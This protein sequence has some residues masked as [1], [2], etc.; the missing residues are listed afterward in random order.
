MEL[1]GISTV[2]G[3]QSVEKTTAN[4]LK[5]LA[6]VGRGDVLVVAGQVC[7]HVDRSERS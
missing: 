4:A 5:T 3:N 1:L 6:M 7:G 2:F